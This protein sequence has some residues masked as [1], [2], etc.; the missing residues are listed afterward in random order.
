MGVLALECNEKGRHVL[1]ALTGRGSLLR[2]AH[3]NDLTAGV[4]AA[5]PAGAVGKPGAVA[6]RAGTEALELDGGV[7]HSSALPRTGAFALG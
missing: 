5:D 2:R 4:G 7:R 1:T 6:L 3:G